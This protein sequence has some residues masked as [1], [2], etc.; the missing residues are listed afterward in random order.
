MV[1]YSKKTG[2]TA[3][4]IICIKAGTKKGHSKAGPFFNMLNN[5]EFTGSL[6]DI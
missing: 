3:Y 6:W 1:L 5:A 2:Y 4:F